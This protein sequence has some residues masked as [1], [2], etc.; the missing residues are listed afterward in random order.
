MRWDDYETVLAVAR[1]GRIPTAANSLKITVSTLFRR[2][3]KIE[4]ELA[5]PIFTR[6]KG[7]YRVNEMGQ[8]I[9]L[10]AERIEQEVTHVERTILGRDKQL[11]GKVTIAASE[12]LAPFF[13]AR[14]VNSITQTHPGLKVQVLSGNHVVSLASGD[15]DLAIR[16]RRPTDEQLFGRKLT[17]IRWAVY[18]AS[19]TL[20]PENEHHAAESIGFAGDPLSEKTME[21]QLQRLKSDKTKLYSNSLILTA[22]LA[23]NSDAGCV[24]PVLLGEQWSG[25]VRL[26][27]PFEH[28]FGELWI[29]CHK[30]L[31]QNSRVRVVFDHLIEAAKLDKDLFHCQ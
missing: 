28:E 23:A 3:E 1:S 20:K 15:A 22:S 25:L 12:V 19:G 26:S 5:A 8:S 7:L 10:A 13:L 11:Q 2:L 31:R 27:A 30:D 18:G 9:V 29:M 14:H 6:A 17:N 24:L 16:P 21:L 4:D